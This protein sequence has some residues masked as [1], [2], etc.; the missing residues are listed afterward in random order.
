MPLN[1]CVL[2]AAALA[3]GSWTGMDDAEV[4]A[5]QLTPT[6]GGN[7][8]M[9]VYNGTLYLQLSGP[10]ASCTACDH[11][12]AAALGHV[13]E[14]EAS[15]WPFSPEAAVVSGQRLDV[16]SYHQIDVLA[17]DL[18]ALLP[19]Y[20]WDVRAGTPATPLVVRAS[21]VLGTLELDV[22]Q[23]SFQRHRSMATLV[24]DIVRMVRNLSGASLPSQ[25]TL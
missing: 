20:D 17:G 4:P 22:T 16:P 1:L 19:D 14:G 11:D 25:C 15:P 8:R 21:S 18:L 3:S 24:C 13:L 6:P 2:S 9:A 23:S 5:A 12:R 7:S 10:E